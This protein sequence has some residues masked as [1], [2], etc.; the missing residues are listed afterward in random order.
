MNGTAAVAPSAPTKARGT[1]EANW[2]NDPTLTRW[3]LRCK[4]LKECPLRCAWDKNN[5]GFRITFFCCTP[6]MISL[7]RSRLSPKRRVQLYADFKKKNRSNAGRK[8]RHC[9]IL[10]LWFNTRYCVFQGWKCLSWA[11]HRRYQGVSTT[12][13]TCGEMVDDTDFNLEHRIFGE[14]VY[15]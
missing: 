5:M 14:F 10:L 9:V 2:K 3:S 12:T 15:I 4:I 1:R 13:R 6:A 7:I 8:R 11:K